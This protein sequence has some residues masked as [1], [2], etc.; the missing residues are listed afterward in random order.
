[1]F[2]PTITITLALALPGNPEHPA[3]QWCVETT[4]AA[5]DTHH[6]HLETSELLPVLPTTIRRPLREGLRDAAAE[7]ADVAARLTD[8]RRS[9][10]GAAQA[11][12]EQEAALPAEPDPEPA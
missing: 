11:L 10:A 8:E 5:S 2:V 3:G 7:F 4:D 6:G 12:T 9:Y 1:M